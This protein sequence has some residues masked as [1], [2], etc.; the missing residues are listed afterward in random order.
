MAANSTKATAPVASAKLGPSINGELTGA[1]VPTLP[2][3]AASA[4][5]GKIVSHCADSI[6]I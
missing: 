4:S 3:G 6:V 1:M 2:P 5:K